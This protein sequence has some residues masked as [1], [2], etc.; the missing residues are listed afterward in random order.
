MD[1]I[2]PLG[3]SDVVGALRLAVDATTGITD[4][5]EAMHRRIALPGPFAAAPDRTSGLTG[6]V[7]GAI[8]G[9]ARAAGGGLATAFEHLVPAFGPS[10]R[11]PR[12]EAV[13]SALAGVFG[14]HLEA[15]G[16]PL[17]KPMTLR[18]AG[19]ALPAEGPI[20]PEIAGTASRG[21][22]LAV[23]GLCMN[24]LQWTRD[25]TARDEDLARRLDLAPLRLDYA[26]GLAIAVNGR[27]LADALEALF[28]RWPRPLDRI[29]LIGHSMGGLLIRSAL[30]QGAA[31]GHR[32]P[33]RVSD[34][35]FLGTPHRG[36]PLERA[37]H[38]LD[39]LLAA[40]PWAG[41]LARLGR[42]RSAGIVDLRHGTVLPDRDRH[43]GPV[44]LPPRVR[45]W[46][47]AGSIVGAADGVGQRFVG[48]GLV[49]VDSALGRHRDPARALGF[50]EARAW[51]APGV[52]HLELMWNAEI[53]DRLAVGLGASA[54]EGGGA[55]GSD[56]G[57]LSSTA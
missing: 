25:G 9:I 17:A 43:G 33:A 34:A 28:D 55:A 4:V 12:R 24:D 30:V 56:P 44:P 19:A 53:W 3:K 40:A 26:S 16:N 38:R 2:P 57:P 39:L 6:L 21:V 13:V 20:P 32:W 8:R 31:A 1:A 48:D 49:P 14:D 29:V 36:A 51:I 45:C 22:L 50:A 37:G 7:Y 52:G 15:T 27:R 42:A 46:A 41:P 18:F 23:H 11:D 10:G 47:V 54:A 5:V 35:I